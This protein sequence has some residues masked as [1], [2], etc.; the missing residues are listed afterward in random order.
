[1][2]LDLLKFIIFLLMQSLI[3]CTYNNYEDL[4]INSDCDLSSLSFTNDIQP[5]F[6]L[7]CNNNMCHGGPFPQARVSLTSHARILEVVADGRL[8][9]TINHNPG[10]NPMPIES[11]KLAGCDIAKIQEWINQGSPDN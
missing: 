6:N 8:I 1:M 10:F 5:I 11:E 2:P 7:H 4:I 9:G 3:S